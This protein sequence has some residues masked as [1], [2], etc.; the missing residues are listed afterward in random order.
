MNEIGRNAPKRSF[1]TGEKALAVMLAAG[2]F[3]FWAGLNL[4][5][6]G[7]ATALPTAAAALPAAVQQSSRTLAP[8]QPP[9]TVA[10]QPLQD[11]G[12]LRAIVDRDDPPIAPF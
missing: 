11:V 6:S 4:A 1:T 12:L 3:G 10:E 2:A 8:N 5:A 7:D 9:A